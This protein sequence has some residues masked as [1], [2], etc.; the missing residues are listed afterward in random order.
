[1]TYCQD[2]LFWRLRTSLRTLDV[3]C[4]IILA[5]D[6]HCNN[7]LPNIQQ[8][9]A[10]SR[11][12]ACTT[13]ESS[14]RLQNTMQCFVCFCALLYSSSFM[15]I[16]SMSVHLSSHKWCKGVQ[17]FDRLQCSRTSQDIP[18]QLRGLLEVLVRP[19]QGSAV[20]ESGRSQGWF[21]DLIMV[22]DCASK[23]FSSFLE[24]ECSWLMIRIKAPKDI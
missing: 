6:R 10:H 4:W 12:A 15:L 1:M 11:W 14:R 24:Q 16:P 7:P 19:R 23:T 21:L 8:E 18:G 13:P 9:P 20:P 22:H 3:G 2:G 5:L 17:S